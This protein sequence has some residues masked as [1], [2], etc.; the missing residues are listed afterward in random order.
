MSCKN[1]SSSSAS[2]A[3]TLD[4]ERREEEE[5]WCLLEE[6]DEEIEREC[7]LLLKMQRLLVINTFVVV[8]ATA[9]LAL[10][11]MPGHIT[12][13]YRVCMRMKASLFLQSFS[14]V[15][16]VLFQLVDEQSV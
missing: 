11:S 4:L 13:L 7:T 10:N 1:N 5:N 6:A 16:Q 2:S 12:A 8:C 14:I 15:F 3:S 9:M